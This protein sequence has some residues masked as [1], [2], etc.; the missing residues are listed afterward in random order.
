MHT[1]AR[2]CRPRAP[3]TA[4]PSLPRSTPLTW[5][6]ALPGP[7]SAAAACFRVA[8]ADLNHKQKIQYVSKLKAENEELKQQVKQLSAAS[9]SA[10][11]KENRARAPRAAA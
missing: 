8:R 2:P 3:H 5:W 10:A 11:N 6:R 4:C 7:A 9:K 1:P